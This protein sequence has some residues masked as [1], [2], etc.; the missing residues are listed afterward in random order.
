MFESKYEVA[1][2]LLNMDLS[3]QGLADWTFKTDPLQTKCNDL[4]LQG[5]IN[6]QN[7]P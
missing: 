7:L 3:W 5:A 4:F 1:V 2:S 6:L